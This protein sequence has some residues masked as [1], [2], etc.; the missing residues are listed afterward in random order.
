MDSAGGE[1]EPGDGAGLAEAV[2]AGVAGIEVKGGAEDGL[3]VLVSVAEDYGVGVFAGEE[4]AQG[5]RGAGGFDDVVE[6]EFAAGEVDDFG[7]AKGG[8][9]VV[10]AENGSDG[11]DLFEGV[12]DGSRPDVAAVEDVIDACEEFGQARIEEAVGFGNDADLHGAGGVGGGRLLRVASERQ[13]G[14]QA[15]DSSGS[16]SAGSVSASSS[17]SGSAASESFMAPTNRLVKSPPLRRVFRK[18]SQ[19]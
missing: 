2:A 18:N 8:V 11:G 3:V 19:V 14:G 16:A 10:V 15:L 9:E 4:G 12:D 13:R 6:E 17:G 1:G 5:G 7:F